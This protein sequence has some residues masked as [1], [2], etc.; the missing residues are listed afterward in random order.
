MRKK[1]AAWTSIAIAA[2]P[3]TA[4]AQPQAS[5]GPVGQTVENAVSFINGYLIPAI[6]AVAF[7]VFIWGMFK[8]FILG[9]A[10]EES[11]QQ[12]KQLALWGVAGF[13]IMLSLWGI[14]AVIT[15]SLNLPSQ[16]PI[17]PTVLFKIGG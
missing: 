13:V 7:L 15:S 9:G 17:L 3:F 6:F 4:G 14:I 16:P 1:L 8:Y 5:G 11:R 2:L 12:G 10:S